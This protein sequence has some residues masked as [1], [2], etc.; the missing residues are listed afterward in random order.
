MSILVIRASKRFAVRRQARLC[1]AGAELLDGLLIEISLEGCRISNVEHNRFAIGQT[2]TVQIDG[3]DDIE[4]RVRWAH[5]GFVGL[6]FTR[7]LHMA[8]L[9]LLIG[10]CRRETGGGPQM[11]SYGT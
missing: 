3:I 1:K 8:A 11:R 2:A 4:G 9:G 7:P 6:R 10:S 5:D